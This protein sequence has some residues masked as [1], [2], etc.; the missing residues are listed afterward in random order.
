MVGCFLI[1]FISSYEF[2]FMKWMLEIHRLS[3]FVVRVQPLISL[4]VFLIPP[5]SQYRGGKRGYLHNT[6][7]PSQRSN[8]AKTFPL[9]EIST[10][11]SGF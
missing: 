6:W 4:T 10:I 1:I 2:Y 8:F 3:F 5:Y 7:Q 11:T 9:T